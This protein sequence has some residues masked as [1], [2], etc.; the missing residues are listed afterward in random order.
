M[1]NKCI[2]CCNRKMQLYINLN[3]RKSWMSSKC[4]RTLPWPACSVPLYIIENAWDI[5]VRRVCGHNR[6]FQ[7]VQGL[8]CMIR[9]V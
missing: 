3:L 4:I 1:E 9:D 2:G 7:N 6:V 5:M 8:G